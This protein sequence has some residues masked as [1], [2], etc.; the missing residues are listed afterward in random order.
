MRKRVTL[1]LGVAGIFLAGLLAGA[2]VSGALPAF[3]SSNGTGATAAS[4]PATTTNTDYCALYEQTLT[5]NLNVSAS[6]WEKANSQ[7]LQAVINQMAKDGKIDAQQQAKLNQQAASLGTS[8]CTKLA[9][10]IRQHRREMNQANGALAG[11]HAA[12]V[13]QVAPTLHLT[14]DQLESDLKNGQTVS[15]IAA[16]QKVNMSD[17][18]AAY[19]SAVQAQLAKAVS[20]G[21]LSQQQSTAI[22]QKMEN[23]AN[24]GHFPLL[25]QHA[26]GMQKG[27]PT[28]T[29][30]A[31]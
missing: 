12:I 23:A 28:A 20:A 1:G 7:A 22:Y 8:T 14:S 29:A 26:H 31:G 27:T 15:Q 10:L 24:S 16:A 17:V 5:K 30:T 25:E 3:A 19:L 6:A 21:T 9:D 2:L 11:A 13:A 18:K 4:T